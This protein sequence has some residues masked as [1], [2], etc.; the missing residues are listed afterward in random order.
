VSALAQAGTSS[1]SLRRSAPTASSDTSTSTRPLVQRLDVALRGLVVQTGLDQQ[2][3]ELVVTSDSRLLAPAEAGHHDV[4]VGVGEHAL[5][6]G[7][8]C[9]AETPGVRRPIVAG[10]R[11]G[12]DLGS[13]SRGPGEAARALR[14]RVMKLG[15][16]H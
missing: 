5:G 10:A 11:E 9:A 14:A 6:G 7:R 8:R 4:A 12:A 2:L 15:A 13:G 3:L 16:H 1:N